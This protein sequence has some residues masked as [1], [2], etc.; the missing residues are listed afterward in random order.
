M[1]TK[2]TKL[3]YRIRS[4]IDYDRLEF[5][6]DE[7]DA[8]PDHMQQL[9]TVAETYYVLDNY[10]D[11]LYPPEEVFRSGNTFICYDP[12]NRNVRISPDWYVAIGVDA[13][14]ITRR[15]LYLPDE[16]GKPPDLVLEVGS[17]ST[18]RVDLDNKPQTYARIGVPEYWRFDPSG[19]EHYGYPL[20][21]D[22]LV[23]GVYEP[24]ELSSEPD[25]VLKGYSMVLGLSLCW[26]EGMLKFYH[27]E[28]GAYL[29]TFREEQAAREAAEVRVGQLEEELRRRQV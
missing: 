13:A 20:A 8:G 4:V 23:N 10:L 9:P 22:R 19:G 24:I 16:V 6:A 7:L 15:R 11:S 2:T 18:A 25:G 17:P 14:A 28:T 3:P 29:P 21:G 5:N 1:T 12:A 27:H 26:R